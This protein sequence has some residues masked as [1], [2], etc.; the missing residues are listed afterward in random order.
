MGEHETQISSLLLLYNIKIYILPR[1]PEL[2]TGKQVG[3]QVQGRFGVIFRIQRHFEGLIMTKSVELRS[4]LVP[5]LNA[6]YWKSRY[7]TDYQYCRGG[8]Y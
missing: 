7:A 3:T 8:Y 4:L 5:M 2:I 6:H 1:W